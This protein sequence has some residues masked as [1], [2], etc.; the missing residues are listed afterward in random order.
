MHRGLR[1]TT[2]MNY[3][4]SVLHDLCAFSVSLCLKKA[5]ELAEKL[6]LHIHSVMGGGSPEGLRAA[7][8]SGQRLLGLQ[9][10]HRWPLEWPQTNTDEHRFDS[11]VL[12]VWFG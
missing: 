4:F 9:V 10:G 1:G 2:G 8:G 6:G 5:R 12:D 11:H 7:H 3:N